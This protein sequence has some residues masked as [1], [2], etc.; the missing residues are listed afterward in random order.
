VA[1]GEGEDDFPALI[2]H[3]MMPLVASWRADEPMSG[4]SFLRI[5]EVNTVKIP[6]GYEAGV[7]ILYTDRQK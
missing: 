4:T 5:R 6:A 3:S 7:P 1:F 2:P